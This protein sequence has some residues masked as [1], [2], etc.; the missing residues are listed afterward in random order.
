MNELNQAYSTDE[1][2]QRITDLEARMRGL[3]I[4]KVHLEQPNENEN[5]KN[6]FSN[7]KKKEIK[8]MD[9]VPTKSKSDLLIQG[10]YSDHKKNSSNSEK[11][12]YI[13]NSNLY[14]LDTEL[15]L[16]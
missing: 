4:K 1:D 5:N 12:P 9:F 13:T 7:S 8:Q 6:N 10:R 11:D 14:K 15:R 2:L 3:P 16:E